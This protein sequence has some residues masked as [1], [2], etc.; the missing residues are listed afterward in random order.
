MNGSVYRRRDTGQ[1]EYRFD[2]GADPLTGRRRTRTK[3][4]FA[5]KRE[6]SAALRTA[7]TAHETGRSVSKSQQSVETFVNQWHAGVKPALRD[8]TWVNYRNYLDYYVIPV[9]GE[10][11]LQDL[12]ALR[13]NLLYA[14]LLEK[15]R[16]RTPGGLA[17]K[18]VQNVH[19]MLHRALRDAVKWN[20]LPRNV[21]EDAEPPRVRRQKPSIWTPEELGQFVTHVSDDRFRALWLLVATTGL[22]RGELAGLQ[23][24]DVDVLHGTVSPSR[25]RVVAAGRAIESD[26]KTRA[27]ERSLALD[28]TTRDALRAYLVMWDEERELLGQDTQLLFV[29]PNGQPLHP[30]TIT[31]LFHRHCDKAGLPR[32][33]LHDVRHSYAT[34][35]LK[36]GVPAKVISERLGHATVAFTLQTYTHVIPGMDQL[37]ADQVAELIFGAEDP[38][39][40]ADVREFVRKAPEAGLG[41][42]E[43]PA[44]SAD[45]RR[46]AGPSS[47]SGGRI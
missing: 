36:T 3:T 6:A 47:G 43:G 28:P 35:A 46:S 38:G 5:T 21:A 14:H 41:E 2:L 27:G 45:N 40:D 37:A 30:D 25:P 8:T 32:I 22:R 20:L 26:T 24:H 29:W 4:G 13:L 33:R 44:D 19:R 15:G 11:R 10:T 42:S 39:Q 7:M 31:T 23:R 18:T 17:P 34:A 9:I 1:W 12:S 16:I